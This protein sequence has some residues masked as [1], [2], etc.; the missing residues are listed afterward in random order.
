M[1][2]DQYYIPKI[3]PQ[4][5]M[6]TCED[7][8]LYLPKD[9]VNTYF[10]TRFI[11]KFLQVF[12]E[13]RVKYNIMD[14]KDYNKELLPVLRVGDYHIS[15]DML[16][17]WAWNSIKSNIPEPEGDSLKRDLFYNR[18]YNL[19]TDEIGSFYDYYTYV[20]KET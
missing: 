9:K 8:E 3:N 2:F 11:T 10:Y 6:D 19:L 12:F 5:N 15:R 1:E 18:V 14:S 7:I 13:G 17:V 16:V 4:E 20:N